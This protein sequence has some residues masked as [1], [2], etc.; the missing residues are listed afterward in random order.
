[1]QRSEVSEFEQPVAPILPPGLSRD[2]EDDA[3]GDD[4]YFGDSAEQQG[5]GHMRHGDPLDFGSGMD[6]LLG[7]SLYKRSAWR[8]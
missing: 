4:Q 6:E 1:V 5:L 7:N 8:I 3:S 2:G